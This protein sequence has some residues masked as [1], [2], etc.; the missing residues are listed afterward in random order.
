L[1]GIEIYIISIS[2]EWKTRAFITQQLYNFTEYLQ[3][4]TFAKLLRNVYC[5]AACFTVFNIQER[6]C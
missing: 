3:R 1:E 2:L 4:W 5:I 6:H